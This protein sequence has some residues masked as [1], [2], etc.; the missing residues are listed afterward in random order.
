MTTVPT[1]SDRVL[2]V[3]DEPEI[4]ALV[5]YHLARAGFRVSSASSGTDAPQI[6]RP[7][8]PALTVLSL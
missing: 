2:V 1:A 6:A 4:V 8:R 5:V 7:E 3:D